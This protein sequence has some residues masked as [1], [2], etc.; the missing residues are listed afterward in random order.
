MWDI[1]NKKQ[2]H[3]LG[4]HDGA[5]SSILCQ[6]SDPQIVTGSMDS[7]IRLWDLAAGKSMATL[8]NHKKGVRADSTSS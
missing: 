1:R 5:V 4:G 7:T 8:T 3:L 2:V 6:G